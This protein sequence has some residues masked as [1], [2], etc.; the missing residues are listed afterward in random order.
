MDSQLI[1][2]RLVD[3][4]HHNF[5]VDTNLVYS[6]EKVARASNQVP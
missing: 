2:I 3:L 1:L 4:V 5:G 6:D